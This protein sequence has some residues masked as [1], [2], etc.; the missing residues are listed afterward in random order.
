METPSPL[1]QANQSV[2]TQILKNYSSK[3]KA[4]ERNQMEEEVPGRVVSLGVDDRGA[5]QELLF[6]LLPFLSSSVFREG[7]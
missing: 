2:Q 1:P 6:L 5:E 3:T 4:E 7:V